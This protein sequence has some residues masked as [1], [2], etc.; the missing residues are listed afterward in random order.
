MDL[1]YS[2][3][4]FCFIENIRFILIGHTYSSQEYTYTLTKE[5]NYMA[6]ENNIPN[7]P[8]EEYIIKI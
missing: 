4:Y 3:H 1:G 2:V 5:L 7:F 6:Q 8:T